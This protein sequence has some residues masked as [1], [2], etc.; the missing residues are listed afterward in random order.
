MSETGIDLQATPATSRVTGSLG[1][2]DVGM[3]PVEEGVG[4]A[5]NGG[6]GRRRRASPTSP[7][8][9]NRRFGGLQGGLAGSIPRGMPIGARKPHLFPGA[10]Q[11]P[12][13]Q[14]PLLILLGSVTIFIF[15]KRLSHI[16]F[17][18]PSV[19]PPCR[20]LPGAGPVDGGDGLRGAPWLP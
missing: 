13:M 15:L 5:V 12:R 19:F 16:P 7:F 14:I 1:V 20:Q 18:R 9:F 4:A 2:W 10:E 17:P 6:S 3:A 8:L 11:E